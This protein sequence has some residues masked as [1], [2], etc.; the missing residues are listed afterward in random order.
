MSNPVVSAYK[1][2]LRD[3]SPKNFNTTNSVYDATN[4]ENGIPN[5][6]NYYSMPYSEY[7]MPNKTS[8][9]IDGATLGADGNK[10]LCK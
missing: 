5:S 3:D 6:E 7:V 1:P 2:Y 4:S 10:I 8:M 9:R